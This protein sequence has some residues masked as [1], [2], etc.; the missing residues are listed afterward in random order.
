LADK[1]A[2]FEDYVKKESRNKD[3]KPAPAP[4][5]VRQETMDIQIEDPFLFLNEAERE[6]YLLRRQREQ[7]KDLHGEE[8]IRQ[9]HRDPI[10]Q[11]NRVP[12]S[13]YRRE[14]EHER[15]PEHARREHPEPARGEIH[16][17][18]RR[19]HS[20]SVRIEQPEPAHRH[21]APPRP[22]RSDR[23]DDYDEDYEDGYDEDE[24]AQEAA[25]RKDARIRR[26]VRIASAMT[27]IL[28]LA[29]VGFVIKVKVFDRYFGTNPE[30]VATVAVA[31]PEGYTQT[32]DTVVV[33][34]A[35]SLNIRSGPGTSSEKIGMV[36][37]GTPL[38]RI[39]V[40][41]DGSWAFIEYEGQ[42]CYASM[43]YLTPN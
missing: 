19:E 43:K 35:N 21:E 31:I 38:K 18:D 24:S 9:E 15:E 37:E 36:A 41:G 42:Y 40:S 26:A 39:A 4:E 16:E 25:Q 30:E 29:F 14:P 13:E 20:D 27:G 28:I 5:E 33:T 8:P 11:E 2:S 32:N 23:D 7:Q 34:G 22:A 10:R 17:R 12:E 3:P 1:I 6:E